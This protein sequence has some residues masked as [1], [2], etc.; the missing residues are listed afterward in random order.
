MGEVQQRLRL[1]SQQCSVAPQQAS[2]HFVFGD[3][4]STQTS[5]SQA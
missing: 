2:P 1:E 3:G 4:Q 5:F